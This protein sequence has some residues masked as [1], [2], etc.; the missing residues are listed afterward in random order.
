MQ[1]VVIK[2]RGIDLNASWH[3]YLIVNFISDLPYTLLNELI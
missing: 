1:V 3:F 2:Q